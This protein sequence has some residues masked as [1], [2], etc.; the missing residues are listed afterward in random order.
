MKYPVKNRLLITVF[1][2][3]ISFCSFSQ[4]KTKVFIDNADV[5]RFEQKG[6]KEIQRLIGNV[7]LRQDSTLFF[8]D[9]AILE[10]TSNNMQAF[11]NVHINYTDSLDIYGDFLD[12]TGNTRIAELD[13]NV[14]LVDDKATLRTDHLIYDRNNKQATYNTGGEIEDEENVL[15]SW[16]GHYYTADKEFFFKDTV[17][18]VNPDYVLRSDTLKYNSDTEIAYIFGPTNITSEEDSIYCEFGWYDTKQNRSKLVKNAFVQKKEQSIEADTIFYNRE[19]DYGRALGNIKLTDTVQ[20]VVVEGNSGEFDRKKGE[21]YVTERAVAIFID[22]QDSLFLHADTIKVLNDSLDRAEK[23]LAYNRMKFFRDDFQGACDSMIY[24]VPDSTIYMYTDPVLWSD[25]NQLTSDSIHIFVSH[26]SI[27]SLRLYSSAFIISKDT[28]AG[29][30]QI[31]GREMTG[32]FRDNDLWRIRVSGN[33]ETLY[34]VREEDGALIG[35]NKSVSSYMKIQLQDN[36]IKQITY[37]EKPDA[38]LV[39]DIKSLGG[40]LKL[41]GFIWIEE[42]RPKTKQEIFE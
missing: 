16:I 22:E 8:C 5:L 18:L 36:D 20:D 2:F 27:D 4:N 26:N 31:K 42:R 35:V 40:E 25:E 13:G 21:S 6:N 10:N 23:L 29:Y 30:N 17:V 15:T 12:Y 14:L 37:L 7:R 3:S 32:Y 9:S 38:N 1:L 33:A 28:V 34:Y 11:G 19:I 39:P 24:S 41:E